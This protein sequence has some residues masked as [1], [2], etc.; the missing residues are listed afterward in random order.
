MS[1]LTG[2]LRPWD[3]GLGDD[4]SEAFFVGVKASSEILSE[5]VQTLE[6]ALEPFQHPRATTRNNAGGV[7][8]ENDVM[9]VEVLAGDWFRACI[10]LDKMDADY[11][12]A[13]PKNARPSDDFIAKFE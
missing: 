3:F 2:S 10:A 8:P 13:L 1:T 7:V 6:E 9:K 11:L 5:R 4:E 12:R